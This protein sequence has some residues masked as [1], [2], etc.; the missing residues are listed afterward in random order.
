MRDVW[1]IGGRRRLSGGPGKRVDGAFSGRPFRAFGIN[2]D[3]WMTAALD[4]G[5]RRRTAEQRGGTFHGEID[6]CR[7]SQGWTM[8]CSSMPERDEKD[9]GEDIPK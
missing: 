2:A 1:R 9:E 5:E 4:E 6:R 8:A 3:Q 7:E